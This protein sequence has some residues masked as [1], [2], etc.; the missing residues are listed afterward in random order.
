MGK[1]K[2]KGKKRGFHF[3]FQFFLLSS[4]GTNFD[5]KKIILALNKSWFMKNKKTV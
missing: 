2:E 3:Q 5:L 1:S 4:I